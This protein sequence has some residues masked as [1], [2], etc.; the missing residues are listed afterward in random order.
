MTDIGVKFGVD[1]EANFKSAINAVN[2]QIK[3]LNSEMKLATSE[4]SGMDKSEENTAKKFDIL[5]K[6]IDTQ[7]EKLGVLEKEYSKRVDKLS[8]LKNELDKT[9]ASENATAKEIEDAASAYN[10]QLKSVTDLEIQINNTNTSIN[11]AKKEQDSLNNTV[12][13]SADNFEEAAN[14]AGVFGDVLSANVV[15]QAIISGLKKVADG[16]KEIAVGAANASD[17]ILTLSSVTGLS[18]DTIQ[19]FQYMADLVDTSFET[20]EGSLTKLV[21]NMQTATKGTGDAAKAFKELGIEVVDSNGELRDNE[22]V[23]YEALE[24]L[25]QIE[26]ETQRDAY[27]MNIFG[28]SARDLNPLIEAGSERM[29]ELAAQ[30]HEYGYVMDEEALEA[31]G[32]FKDSLDTLSTS[33]EALKRTIGTFFAPVLNDIATGLLNIVNAVQEFTEK[34]EP[35]IPL[36]TGLITA[37]GA[38]AA[39]LGIASLIGTVSK[40]FAALNAIMAA[41]PIILVVGLIAGLVAALITAYKTNDEFRAEVQ[42]A[43]QTLKDFVSAG[44]EKIKAAAETLK[45]LPG[46]ALQWGKDMIQNFINGI[47]SMIN[48][49]KDAVSNVAQTVKNFLGF[50]EPKMGPLSNFHTYGPDMMQLYAKGMTD[51]IGV[52]K[53]AS[54]KVASAV[55]LDASSIGS[56]QGVFEGGGTNTIIVQSVLDGKV[57]GETAFDYANNRKVA[58]GR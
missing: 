30:A 44:I 42:E 43:W 52:I 5:S 22:D 6:T 28:K 39:G 32:K 17:D 41:N 24:A 53:N 4:M 48:K 16:I 36:I 10:R 27:A 23:F 26:N 33:Q 11:K 54:A 45:E 13:E 3:S 58:F 57:I 51:N 12:E 29:K 18:T 9:R 8:A 14:S 1:N 40:A 35:L 55:R 19:E 31:N 20:I 21:K 46:K 2:A 37:L 7:T 47:K 38:L 34:N 25:G 50:S 56:L 15:S 49:V